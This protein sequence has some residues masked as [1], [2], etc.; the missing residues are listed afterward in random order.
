MDVRY[1]KNCKQMFHY[2]GSPLCPECEKEMEKKFVD[3]KNYIK[4]NPSAKMGDVAE[5][6]DVPM[7]QI[8]RWIREERLS[9]SKDSGV[10]LSCE[11]CGASI[12]TGRFCQNCKNDMAHQFSG[13]YQPAKAEQAALKSGDSKSKMRF[14]GKE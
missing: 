5:E 10:R 11:K 7:Q 13:I 4:E 3:V 1:C 9:F 6:N 2:Q 14:L 12:T 8:K